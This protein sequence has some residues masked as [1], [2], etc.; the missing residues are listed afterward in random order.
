MSIKFGDFYA[1]PQI[2]EKKMQ[3]SEW[4][5]NLVGRTITHQPT[6]LVIRFKAATDGSGAMRAE[7]VNPEVLPEQAT[8]EEIER[9]SRLPQDGWQIYAEASE[10]A[11]KALEA[12]GG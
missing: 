6:G 3:D 12:D 2:R 7:L 10:R 5:I 8:K 11:L 9:L 1:S 4:K